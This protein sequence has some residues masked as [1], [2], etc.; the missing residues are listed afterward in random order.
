M[1]RTSG[2]TGLVLPGPASTGTGSGAEERLFARHVPPYQYTCAYCL[3]VMCQASGS[4]LFLLLFFF[5]GAPW[6]G[7]SEEEEKALRESRMTLETL[8]KSIIKAPGEWSHNET[9]VAVA[10]GS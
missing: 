8:E 7:G 2:Q 3:F 9:V 1:A 10:P 5:F 4:F 6:K